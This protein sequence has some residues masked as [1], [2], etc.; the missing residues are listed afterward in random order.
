MM[1]TFLFFLA[2]L[3]FLAIS[4]VFILMFGLAFL[5]LE[6][7]GRN[8]RVRAGHGLKC[9]VNSKDAHVKVATTSGCPFS[10]TLSWKRN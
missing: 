5:W 9:Y 7:L 4:P 6:R 1:G 3:G 8:G 10:N 2:F